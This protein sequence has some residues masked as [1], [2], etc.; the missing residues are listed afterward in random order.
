[1][2]LVYYSAKA[3]LLVLRD[4][5]NFFMQL[6]IYLFVYCRK[7]IYFPIES[8]RERYANSKLNCK[9]IEL[10]LLFNSAYMSKVYL[11]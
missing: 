2:K 1:M 6:V 10:K 7:F 8:Y 11:S 3:E 4:R 9:Q 5:N